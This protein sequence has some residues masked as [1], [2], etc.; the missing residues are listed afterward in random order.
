MRKIQ[1]A[2][3]IELSKGGTMAKPQKDITMQDLIRQSASKARTFT[4][5]GVSVSQHSLADLIAADKH[6][7]KTDACRAPNMGLR[8]GRIRNNEGHF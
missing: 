2:V 7:R 1:K 4:A 8:I 5:D 6:M 3:K